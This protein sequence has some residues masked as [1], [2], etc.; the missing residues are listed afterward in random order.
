MSLL[1]LKKIQLLTFS[2]YFWSVICYVHHC[3]QT[4]ISDIGQSLPNPT[5]RTCIKAGNLAFS[6]WQMLSLMP[7]TLPLTA[8]SSTTWVTV[9]FQQERQKKKK[10]QIP[11]FI[12]WPETLCHL[13]SIKIW[14]RRHN[15]GI[16]LSPGRQAWLITNHVT[17][18]VLTLIIHRWNGLQQW[19]N[20][21]IH[22]A[23]QTFSR[24]ALHTKNV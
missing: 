15:K 23:S 21:P 24:S 5:K 14:N 7:A 6:D 18:M 13:A 8:Q 16:T 19:S 4:Q 11:K 22:Q 17:L 9:H 2:A 12:N 3:L 10:T 1:S 20:H